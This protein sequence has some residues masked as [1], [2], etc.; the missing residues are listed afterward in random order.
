M[1]A[2]KG[3][4]LIELLIVVAIIGIVAAIA[5][6]GLQRAKRSSEEAAAIGCLR[7]YSSAQGAYQATKGNLR[8]YGLPAELA[9]GYLDPQLVTGP[10]RNGYVFTFNLTDNGRAFNA[11]ANPLDNDTASRYFFVDDSHVIRYENGAPAT[12][13]STILGT[14]T[15]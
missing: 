5:I 8:T 14:S 12:T 13:A 9:D 6:P 11:T 1:R 3:F 2:E 10:F 15:N 7:A 4:S